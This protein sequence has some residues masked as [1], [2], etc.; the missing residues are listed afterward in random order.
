MRIRRIVMVGLG[1]RRGRAGTG[2]VHGHGPGEG[3]G[4]GGGQGY[5]GARY[6]QTQENQVQSARGNGRGQQAQSA[7]DSR[8]MSSVVTARRGRCWTRRG[9]RPAEEPASERTGRDVADTGTLR[10]LSGTLANDGT[11]WYL[12]AADG[13]YLLH[14]GNTAYVE[15]TGLALE[16]GDAAVVKGLVDA[17]EVSVVSLEIN[18]ETYTFRSEDGRPLWAGGGRGA[19]RGGGQGSGRAAL[20]HLTGRV[21]DGGG[22][23][24]RS[25]PAPLAFRGLVAHHGPRG[26]TLASP[27]I[28]GH[29]PENA[30]S[31][32]LVRM[33]A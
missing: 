9:A 11:E 30:R 33:A 31:C 32:K 21:L 26:T 18:G 12:D 24:E 4:Q 27:R 17:D 10:T 16:A 2:G 19:G 22:L 3:N 23:P 6:V 28:Q 20:P 29:L 5:R 7:D 1:C 8:R 14:L 15:Q 13:R 25:A